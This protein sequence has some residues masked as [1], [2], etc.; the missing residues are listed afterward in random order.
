MR[1]GEEKG[2]RKR[3]RKRESS[4][5]CL[6]GR[7]RTLMTVFNHDYL[8]KDVS[9]SSATVRVRASTYGFGEGEDTAIQSIMKKGDGVMEPRAWIN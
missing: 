1:E 8:V 5:V 4:L 2:G 9:P 3:E 7:T 6:L